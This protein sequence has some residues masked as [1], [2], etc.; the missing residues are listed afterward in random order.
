MN[1]KTKKTV[2]VVA[3]KPNVRKY[4]KSL[5][6]CAGGVVIHEESRGGPAK[7]IIEDKQPALLVTDIALD[8]EGLTGLDLAILV[9][10]PTVLV[11]YNLLWRNG[12]SYI[13]QSGGRIYPCDLSDSKRIVDTIRDCL[14]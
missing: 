6:K 10:I 4:L 8:N 9:N 3:G 12:V 1:E 2:V 5:V 14:A 13:A 11:R 7:K